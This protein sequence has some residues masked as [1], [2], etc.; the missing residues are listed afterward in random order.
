MMRRRISYLF[1]AL[2]SLLLSCGKEENQPLPGTCLEI[3]VVSDTSPETKVPVEGIDEYLHENKINHVDFYFYPGADT[4][5]PATYHV[6]MESGK[7]KSAFFRLDVGRDVVNNLIFPKDG[8]RDIHT[9]VVY[10]VVNFPGSD[11]PKVGPG[12]DLSL[13]ALPNLRK[14][15]DVRNFVFPNLAD[16]DVNKR[17][18]HY[19]PDFL[20]DGKVTMQLRG[21]NMVVVA[22]PIIEVKRFASK[23]TVGVKVKDEVPVGNETWMPMLD[24]MEIYLVNAMCK[25]KLGGRL[26]GRDETEDGINEMEKADYFSFRNNSMRF[27]Y[28]DPNDETVLH[29]YFEKSG[30]FYNTYPFYMYPQKWRHSSVDPPDM[31]PYLKLVI[32]WVRVTYDENGRPQPREQKQYY[33]KIVIPDDRREPSRDYLCQFVRNNWYHINVNVEFL[34]AETD[35]ATVTVS[36]ASVYVVYWQDKNVVVKN[37]EIGKARYLSV[38]RD[39]VE[40]HNEPTVDIVFASSHQTVITNVRATRPYYGES[41]SG[42]GPGGKGVIR[43]AGANDSH[44]YA[45]NTYYLDFTADAT[46]NPDVEG[47]GWISLDEDNSLI[48]FKHPLEN[49]YQVAAFDYSPY[50]VTFQLV[51]ADQKDMAQPEYIKDVKIV[52]I[53]GIYIQVWDNSDHNN[54]YNGYVYIDGTQYRRNTPIEVAYEVVAKWYNKSE[55]GGYTYNFSNG[56]YTNDYTSSKIPELQDLQWR[57]INYTG[58]SKALYRINISVLP[59]DSDFVI[60]DARMTT[61]DNLEDENS[62]LGKARFHGEA[63][64]TGAG[65]NLQAMVANAWSRPAWEE[66]AAKFTE[67][68]KPPEASVPYSWPVQNQSAWAKARALEG[69]TKDEEGNITHHFSGQPRAL[70]H[71]YPADPSERTANLMAPS[72]LIASKFGGVEYYQGTPYAEAVYRCASYQEDGYPAGRWRLPTRGEIR[73]IAMLSANNAFTFLFSKNGTYWSANGAVKVL[74]NDVEDVGDVEYAMGRC[75]YDIW[76][77]GDEDKLTGEDR[78]IFTW[79]DRER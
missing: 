27:C 43:K 7:N 25:V 68:P 15:T 48:K 34:G 1:L 38:D 58:G 60:G 33:Y 45:A 72:Y 17:N 13:T 9:C 28:S 56:R 79:G 18:S 73:F 37:A 16:E 24:G 70:E 71:Y 67:T 14:E 55:N 63:T 42:D 47:S 20:M 49:R 65:P 36:D 44:G 39:E 29:T 76:Y 54:S 69:I 77:W 32:P 53:P 6:R 51:H 5:S 59:D 57:V 75:V 52:Q 8:E 22:S 21:R 35:E 2:L 26:L 12:E 19:H 46:P 74:T 62:F 64:E 30:D 31:E 66:V 78:K 50:T 4:L 3:T 11:S 10:A 40:I 41:T 61:K 23:L